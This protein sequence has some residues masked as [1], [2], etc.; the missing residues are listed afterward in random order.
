MMR[1]GRVVYEVLTDRESTHRHV[2]QLEARA[3][4]LTTDAGSLENTGMADRDFDDS[5]MHFGVPESSSPTVPSEVLLGLSEQLGHRRYPERHLL[6]RLSLQNNLTTKFMSS[7]FTKKN[8]C[9]HH[10]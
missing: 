1:E 3:A 10:T 4:R 9:E 6:R 7:T 8:K 2:D 5:S